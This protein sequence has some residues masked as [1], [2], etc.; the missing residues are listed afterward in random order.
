MI[1]PFARFLTRSGAL[2][3]FLYNGSPSI[4]AERYASDITNSKEINLSP[5]TLVLSKLYPPLLQQI[6]IKPA[7]K[8]TTSKAQSRYHNDETN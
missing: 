8:E 2:D 1:A 4:V 6:P 3:S 7:T 5:D